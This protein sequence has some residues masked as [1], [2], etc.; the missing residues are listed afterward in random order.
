MSIWKSRMKSR[1]SASVLAVDTPDGIS[2]SK[3]EAEVNR[4]VLLYLVLAGS[5][6][7]L[8]R[9]TQKTK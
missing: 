5:C 9:H 3:E 8:K 2:Q 6:A 4:H 7:W 1:L